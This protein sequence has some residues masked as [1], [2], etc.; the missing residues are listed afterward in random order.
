MSSFK[1]ISPLKREFGK[2]GHSG[3]LDPFATGVLVVAVNRATKFIRFLPEEKEYVFSIQFGFRTDTDDLEGEV[4]DRDE[5]LPTLDEVQSVL[6]GFVG[7]ILQTPSKFSS[8]KIAGK[9]AYHLARLGE[10]FVIKSRAV[11][12]EFLK[13]VDFNKDVLTLRVK[14]SSGTYVR[15]LMSDICQRLGCVGCVVSLRR[16]MSNGFSLEKVGEVLDLDVF[17]SFYPILFL[18][19]EEHVMLKYGRSIL[20]IGCGNGIFSG[21]EEWSKFLGLVQVNN[22]LVSALVLL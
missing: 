11:D 5:R 7:K 6:P 4:I 17:C 20:K 10:E 14:C 18:S 12:I 16:M 9:R 1:C 3:T 22:N 21:V 8:V 13:I 19:N 15:S 2:I